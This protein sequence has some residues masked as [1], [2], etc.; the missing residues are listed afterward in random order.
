V[1]STYVSLGRHGDV[2]LGLG[3]RSPPVCGHLSVSRRGFV[4]MHTSISRPSL[5]VCVIVDPPFID[6][7]GGRLSVAYRGRS[8]YAVV[9]QGVLPR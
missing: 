9:K 7:G 4:S 3:L 2:L 5:F 8:Y 1:L 6:R